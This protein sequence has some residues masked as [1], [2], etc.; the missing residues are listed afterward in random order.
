[1]ASLRRYLFASMNTMLIEST[2]VPWQGFSI[3]VMCIPELDDLVF[4]ESE[5]S[6][7]P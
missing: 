5:G 1:M 6:I 7:P 2:K 4:V 3:I